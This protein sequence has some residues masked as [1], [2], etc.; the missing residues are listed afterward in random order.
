MV[1]TANGREHGRAGI[2]FTPKR[3]E[4]TVVD[5]TDEEVLSRQQ[6]GEL[7]V[8]AWGAEQIFAGLGREDRGLIV[9]ASREKRRGSTCRRSPPSNWKPRSK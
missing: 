7:V 1:S 3:L 4:V 5:A 9:F 8:N 2:V 6:A